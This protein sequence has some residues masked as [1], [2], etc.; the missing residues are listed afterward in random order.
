MLF[1]SKNAAMHDA[2]VC[3]HMK[4]ETYFTLSPPRISALSFGTEANLSPFH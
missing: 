1:I 3:R 2:I 4:R